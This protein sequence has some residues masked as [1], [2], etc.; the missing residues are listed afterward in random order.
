M[1]RPSFFNDNANRSYPL[2]ASPTNDAVPKYG[3]ADF[4]CTFAPEADYDELTDYVYLK[5]IRKIDT[6]IEFEFHTTASALSGAALVFRFTTADS[7]Y[8]TVLA[9]VTSDSTISS[10]SYVIEDFPQDCDAEPIWSG[11]M[12]CG[13]LAT[14]AGDLTSDISGTFQVEPSVVKNHSF[15]Y[16]RS[17]TVYNADR[18]RSDSKSGCRDL[19]WPFTVADHYQV[20]SCLAGNIAFKEGYNCEIR[21]DSSV[22]TI[23]I[24]AYVGSGEGEVCTIPVVYDAEEAPS[25]RTTLD[26]GL[27]C[28]EVVRSVN[29]VGGRILR[30]KGVDGVS[31]TSDLDNNKVII[32]VDMLNMQLCTDFRDTGDSFDV[33][34]YTED[35]CDCGPV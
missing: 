19:C 22:N 30:I 14:L 33:S 15:G 16:V 6:L 8:T 35:P 2:L 12:T 23:V 20:A 31:V 4:G 32:N 3:I 24:N 29:G 1:S 25:G 18:T 7:E 26:G 34:S 21:Q 5:E 13:D 10:S 9:D 11:Y 27:K 17:I 28:S